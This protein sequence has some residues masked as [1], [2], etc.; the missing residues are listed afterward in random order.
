EGL[1][2]VRRNTAAGYGALDR[3]PVRNPRL[4]ELCGEILTLRRR[5]AHALDLPHVEARFLRRG[6]RPGLRL[7][8]E[9]TDPRQGEGLNPHL[10]AV[11]DEV[12]P[13]RRKEVRVHG[14]QDQIATG[15]DAVRQ[16]RERWGTIEEDVVIGW[17]LG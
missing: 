14:N 7:V 8:H 12:R 9:D 13:L 1:D 2:H 3:D 15:Q 6:L 10:E 4:E 17:E 16:E 5:G 11:Q